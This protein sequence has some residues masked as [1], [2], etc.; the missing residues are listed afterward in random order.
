MTR[1][2]GPHVADDVLEKYVMNTLS[3]QDV[4]P[5]EEHLLVCP[6]CQDR[7]LETEEFIQVTKAALRDS[8]RRPAVRAARASGHDGILHSWFTLPLLSAVVA[9]VVL[10]FVL[11]RH[12]VIPQTAPNEVRLFA[13]RGS[14]SL[15][16]AQAGEPLTVNLEASELSPAVRYRVT[17]VDSAGK[18]VWTGMAGQI[19]RDIRISLDPAP[20]PGRYWFRVYRDN[21]LVRE[22]GLELQ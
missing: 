1:D 2:I 3:E 13:M 14:D 8:Q 9:A 7:V 16:H 15:V 4:G 21:D 19:G 6:A 20:H 22:Y 17:V 12:S 18:Q 10:G 11:P 5:V